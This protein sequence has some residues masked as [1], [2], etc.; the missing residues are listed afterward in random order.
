MGKDKKVIVEDTISATADGAPTAA[1][2]TT[3]GDDVLNIKVTEST[4]EL[5]EE[6]VEKVNTKYTA[7]DGQEYEITVPKFRFKGNEYISAEAV[8]QYPELLEDLIK[9]NSFIF[10]K[11]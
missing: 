1:V 5:V 7:E 2:N 4:E 10:K 9:V 11:I 3:E 8:D 6:V